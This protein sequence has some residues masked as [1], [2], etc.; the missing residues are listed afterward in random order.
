[1]SL[2]SNIASPAPHF[3]WAT[4]KLQAAVDDSHSEKKAVTDLF[5][6]YSGLPAKSLVS[7]YPW[8]RG[9][10]SVSSTAVIPCFFQAALTGALV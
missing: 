5:V 3:I 8:D 10:D 1:M 7:L 6:M 2:T 4:N 9:P